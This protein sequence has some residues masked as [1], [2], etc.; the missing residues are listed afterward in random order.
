MKNGQ[1]TINKQLWMKT[2][3][4]RRAFKKTGKRP[5]QPTYQTPRRLARS[6]A[7]AK[8]RRQGFTH[9]NKYFSANWRNY[10]GAA[11]WRPVKRR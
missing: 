3:A 10:V 5:D 11:I 8:M 6:I 2:L 9:I 4:E 7:K 1:R